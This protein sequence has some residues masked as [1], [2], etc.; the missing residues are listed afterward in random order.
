MKY[1][2]KKSDAYGF[3]DFV[4][5]RVK[6]HGNELQFETCPYC[7]G[8][9]KHDKWTFSISKDNGAFNCKRAKCGV[10]G[11]MFI[12]ARDFGFSLGA[13]YDEYMYRRKQFRSLQTPKEAIIPKDPAIKYLKTR[14]ISEETAKRYEITVQ[15]NHENVLVFPFYDDDGLLQFVKYR[16]TDFDKTKDKAKEWCEPNCRPIL[17]GMKQCTDDHSRL[18][19]TEGQLD[20]LSVAEAGIDNAVSVPTG[21]KGF[22]W[23]PYCWDWMQSFG[24]VVVFG[25]FENGKVTL[26]DDIKKRFKMRIKVVRKKDYL[27][28]K[29][30]NELLMKHGA[31]AVRNAVEGAELLPLRW[32]IDI[33]DV[34]SV[35]VFKIPKLKTGLVELDKLLYGGLPFGGITL[36]TAKP[37]LGKSTLASQILIHAMEQGYRCFAYSGE[38][39]NSNFKDSLM[40]QIAGGNHIE[41]YQDRWYQN[42][43]RISETNQHLISEWCRGKLAIFTEDNISD[44]DNEKAELVK[45]IENEI[46]QNDTKVFL[47]DNLMTALDLDS[48]GSY[49]KYDKQSMFC[50]R[51][52]RIARNKDVLF[53]LVAH[54]RKNNFSSNMNDEI[55]GSSDIANLG[56]VVL[57]YDDD[58]DD[59]NLLPTQRKLRVTKNR[60]FGRVN[61]DGW[62]YNFDEK[63]KRIYSATSEL[64]EEFS[65]G[66][67]EKDVFTDV[68]NDEGMVF[69]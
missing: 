27:D 46:M 19:I 4:H 32:T 16:K 56:T 63:S 26:L 58:P 51:L 6:D 2:F 21:A 40:R 35:D 24:E 42:Q 29:D 28:C 12:L 57:S 48:S 1:E 53:I 36:I 45:I 68:P 49:D 15:M 25:D 10:S 55:A 5:I 13:E 33:A 61:N 14:G 37:G 17:F 31:E 66:A 18:V 30:A 22:T 52:A 62:I 8:G 23:V 20:S 67:D 69:D 7:K 38:L 11:G 60:L 39:T 59:Q 65:W 54:K 34:Q 50:K 64:R 3:A 44:E 43:Y 9:G 47:V 41:T